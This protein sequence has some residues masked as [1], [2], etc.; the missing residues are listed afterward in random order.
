[1]EKDKRNRP[2]GPKA[3]T[4]PLL[5]GSVGSFIFIPCFRHSPLAGRPPGESGES[6]VGRALMRL[7]CGV[8]GEAVAPTLWRSVRPLSL[9]A[10]LAAL[11][12]GPGVGAVGHSVSTCLALAHRAPLDRAGA[13]VC[14]CGVSSRTYIYSASSMYA[15]MLPPRCRNHIAHPASTL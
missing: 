11:H 2:T 1:M 15:S 12:V 3:L 13:C 10:G 5:C 4:L 7:P 8:M 14:R 6:G 9:G